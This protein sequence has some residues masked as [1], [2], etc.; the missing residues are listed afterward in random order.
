[1]GESS[2][3]T[4]TTETAVETASINGQVVSAGTQIFQTVTLSSHISTIGLA[5]LGGAATGSQSFP[6]F[7]RMTLTFQ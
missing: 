1:M 5:A 7:I 4:T 3:A 2:A 6:Q